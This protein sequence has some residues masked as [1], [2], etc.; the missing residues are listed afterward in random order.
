MN[1]FVAILGLGF[2]VFI[3][4]A[5]HF[6]TARAV[7]MTPAPVLCRLPAAALP[8]PAQGHRVRNRSDP[9]RGLREDPRDAPPGPVRPGHV[10]RAGAGGGSAACFRR[11]SASSAALRRATWRAPESLL[12]ELEQ[13][14]DEASVSP[15]AAKAA[16]KGLAELKDGLGGDAYWRQRTW[17]KV[18]V[19]FAGPGTNLLFAIVVFSLLF[20]IAGE[21]KATRTIESVVERNAGAEGRPPA[22][23]RGHRRQRQAREGRQDLT[24]DHGSEGQP[25]TITVRRDGVGSP[26]PAR[27][28]PAESVNGAYR[29]GFRPEREGRAP[30]PGRLRWEIGAAHRRHHEGDRRVAGRLVRGNKKEVSSPVGIVE[31]SSEA[32][33]QGAQTYFWVL[34]LLSLSL[35]LLN[36]LPLLP[37]DGGHIAF[38]I[39]EGIR[40]RAVGREVYERVSA[41]GI[42]LVLLL[43]FIGLSNDIGKI[44]G[45]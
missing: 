16:R 41:V 11:S 45:N 8:R 29:L 3:H 17:K 14:V 12:P 1:I 28:G 30:G 22:R 13:A 38:S 4:E 5:G 15:Q 37:L 7:G 23:R 40:G 39:I 21:L 6:F 20:L 10:P 18:A 24:R 33:E 27:T 42:A 26:D 31:G 35:A 19:I 44:G 25:L 32:L 2:L 34:G 9:A 36:L 43:F